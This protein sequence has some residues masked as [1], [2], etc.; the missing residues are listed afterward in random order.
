MDK[1]NSTTAAFVTAF[2]PST[3]KLSE[4][5]TTG[6]DEVT[7]LS[8]DISG[9]FLY[10]GGYD[11]TG[12]N[13]WRYEKRNTSTG[14]TSFT[15]P[16]VAAAANTAYSAGVNDIVHL[17]MLINVSAAALYSNIASLKL[18]VA[19][20]S[21]TCDTAFSGET[22][23]D[24]A[25]SSG[26]VRYYDNTS[27]A[28]GAATSA[29]A[30]DPTDGA[31][32]TLQQTYQESNNF[33]NPTTVNLTQDGLWDFAIG[34]SDPAHTALGAYCFRAV[35]SDGTT[36]NISYSAIPELQYCGRPT[37][38]ASLRHGG[39]FC[40]ESKTRFYWSQ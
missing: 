38:D 30:G 1:I 20:K 14:A 36:T 9:G 11:S 40:N 12:A 5:V 37:T 7:T 21:G 3:G 26:S 8:L 33:S 35:N 24:V 34:D 28:N 29:L 39:F 18:Q 22:Y 4:D 32:A 25:G 13:Q 17:R 16:T 27:L 23:V 19:S 31:N 15:A 6:D 2:I 10:V